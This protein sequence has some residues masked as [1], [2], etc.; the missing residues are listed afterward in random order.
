MMLVLLILSSYIKDWLVR[1]KI[2][3]LDQTL[4]KDYKLIADQLRSECC[5][6]PSW[7]G[8]CLRNNGFKAFLF[9]SI[10]I[11]RRYSFNC[12]LMFYERLPDLQGALVVYQMVDCYDYLFLKP[13]GRP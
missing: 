9:A 1:S 13:E 11:D 7:G 5:S 10:S 4:A 3:K 6:I 2:G 12:R 8:I